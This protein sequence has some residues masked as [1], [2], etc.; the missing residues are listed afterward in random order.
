M[1]ARVSDS[2]NF[3]SK[4][5]FNKIIN[6]TRLFI[7]YNYSRVLRKSFHCAMPATASIEPTTSCNL[8]CP[9]CPS[10]LRS[11]SRPIGMLSSYDYQNYI[12]QLKKNL[13]FLNLYFQG[14]PFLNKNICEM[15]KYAS[16]NRIYTSTSSNAHFINKTI[17]EDIVKSGLDRIIISIDGANETSYSKYRIGGTLSKVLDGTNNLVNAK[18]ELKSSNPYIIWQFIVF[19]HN[20]NEIDKIKMLAKKYK[21]DRL[22]IKTAQIYN[23]S[24]N[25]NDLI[26]ENSKLSR[27]KK[28]NDYSIKN[29]LMNHCW[30]MWSS[31]VITWD[32]MVVACCYDKDAKYSFGNIQNKNFNKIW[33]SEGYQRFRNQIFKSRK[34]IDICRNC[35][36]GTKV[37][38]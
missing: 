12:N 27:Y 18:K 8:Q 23:I 11:F 22:K 16:D 20:E 9:E 26:P 37:W 2:I 4:L 14:E 32:G 21:I 25:K 31:C 38:I 30:R 15:I 13:I 33:R 29:K 34:D 1:Q 17:A 7:S 5:S 36:E 28:G 6:F 35:S 3:I 19:K 10:G 24:E